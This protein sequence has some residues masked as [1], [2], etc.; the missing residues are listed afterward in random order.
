MVRLKIEAEALEAA[1]AIAKGTAGPTA[2]QA[3]RWLHSK[4]SKGSGHGRGRPSNDEV[5]NEVKRIA[6]LESDIQSDLSRIGQV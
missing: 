6:M 5:R 2:L 3:A 4:V 1:R